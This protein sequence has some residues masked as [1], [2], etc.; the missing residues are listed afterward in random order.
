M[1]CS[2]S[3]ILEWRSNP[4]PLW[5]ALKSSGSG[6]VELP[7]RRSGQSSEAN[8]MALLFFERKLVGIFSW[9]NRNRCRFQLKIP[10]E[11]MIICSSRNVETGALCFALWITDCRNGSASKWFPTWRYGSWTAH[12]RVICVMARRGMPRIVVLH[13]WQVVSRKY[14]RPWQRNSGQGGWNGSRTIASNWSRPK[15]LRLL[16]TPTKRCQESDAYTKR[17]VIDLCCNS[18]KIIQT[19]CSQ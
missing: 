9:Q 4:G 11:I 5:T 2:R 3:Q 10:T 12:F 14:H 8:T 16:R 17:T 18:C 7:T 19:D 15:L 1:D 6:W 13:L